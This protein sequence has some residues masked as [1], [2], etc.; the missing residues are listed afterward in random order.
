MDQVL[1]LTAQ[2][3][4]L[5]RLSPDSSRRRIGRDVEV[6]Q[7][8]SQVADEEG[9]VQSLHI[10]RVDHEK[11]CVPD[12]LELV[13]QERSPALTS[14]P[15]RTTP[16][17]ATYRSVAD[18]IPSL[19]SSPRIRS[20][21]HSAFSRD[22]RAINALTS[23]LSRG[24]PSRVRDLHVQYRRQPCDASQSRLLVARS[25]GDPP[26]HLAIPAGAIPR[27]LDRQ[28]AS[29][30]SAWPARAPRA[31]GAIPGSRGLARGGSDKH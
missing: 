25:A 5:D 21:P 15:A 26:S 19:S 22:I 16:S 20:V 28:H 18:P 2:G 27:G 17:I 13:A 4:S 7:L 14:L 31:G 8:P 3:G 29:A 30:L 12:A 9:H 10:D 24:R 11:V 6:D 1:R 23:G